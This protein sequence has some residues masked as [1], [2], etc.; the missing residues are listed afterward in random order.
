MITFLHDKMKGLL[1]ILLAV[2]AISFIFFGNWTP[3]GGIDPAAGKMGQ[4]GGRTLSLNDLVAAQRQTLLE[5]TLETGRIPS[6]NDRLLAVQ[7]WIRLLQSQAADQAGIEPQPDQLLESIRKNPLFVKD[8]QYDPELFQRF[9]ENFLNPQGFTG[10]RFNQA[11]QDEVRT[12]KLLTALSS[13]ATVFPGEAENRLQKLF[14]PVE[15]Q[16]LRWDGS[17][18]TPP[19]PTPQDLETFHKNNEQAFAIPARVTVEYVEFLASGSE[20]AARTKA[21]EAAFA[22]TSQFFNL[23]EGQ[24]RPD[25]TA[26]AAEAKLPVKTA[27]PFTAADTPFPGETDPRLTAAALRLTPDDPV[28]DFLPAKN[29]FLVL[30]LKDLQPGRVRPLAEAM[31][32]VKSRWQEQ[33]RLQMAN[34]ASRAFLDRANSELARGAKWD[35][36]IK[37]AG[38]TATKVPS[39]APADSKPLSF[40]DADRIRQIVTQLEPNRVSPFIRTENGGLAVYLAQRLPVSAEVSSAQLPK[41]E[42]QLLNQ[43]RSQLGRDWLVGRAAQPGNELPQ[44]VVQLLRGQF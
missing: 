36:L 32:E 37:A 4:I 26:K 20:E 21:G 31:N 44:E 8:G 28:S 9:S 22:F 14:G 7:T 2:I 15:A 10:E 29:G 42:A 35:D 11:I 40:P 41:I 17:K 43:R 19:E 3:S 5:I 30:R 6:D 13:T 1:L 18:M 39:F 27:G 23:P 34:Q 25:F 24:G 38:L 16:V 33:A 12:R